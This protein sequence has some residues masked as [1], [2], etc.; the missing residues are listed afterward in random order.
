MN[1]LKFY[2]DIC[3]ILG[4]LVLVFIVR[5]EFLYWNRIRIYNLIYGFK[6]WFPGVIFALAFIYFYLKYLK[7]KK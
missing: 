7:L 6:D 3:I 5:F 4:I 2:K 1:K